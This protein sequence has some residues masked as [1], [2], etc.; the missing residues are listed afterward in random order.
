MGS[1]LIVGLGNP[2]AEYEKTRHNVGFWVL[3]ALQA[4]LRADPWKTK[5]GAEWVKL[6]RGGDDLV[7]CKPQTFMNKSGEPTQA[8]AQ[9]FKIATENVIVV[10]DE[11]DF[12]PGTVRLKQGGGAGG[13]NG[14]RSL[15]ACIGADFVRVRAGIGKPPR[16]GVEHVLGVP[17]KAERALLDEGVVRCKDAVLA[18][19]A[20]GTK[21]AM[22]DVNRG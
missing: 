5:F 22:N 9:F 1:F 12:P 14:L 2:G 13:H 11:L 3:D 6:S 10:H 8:L 19:I 15:I 7:L 18:V 21:L 20:K 17:A 4:E 16:E